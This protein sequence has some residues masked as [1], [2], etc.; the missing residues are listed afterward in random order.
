[1]FI[2][3][4]YQLNGKTLQIMALPVGFSLCLGQMKL[5]FNELM[6][7]AFLPLH[8]YSL[9]LFLFI[10]L[11]LVHY[12]F[13]LFSFPLLSYSPYSLA[14]WH[15]HRLPDMVSAGRH[16][17]CFF[18]AF[19]TSNSLPLRLLSI[20]RTCCPVPVAVVNSFILHLTWNVLPYR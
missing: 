8:D 18:C 6:E 13:F 16:S 10:A 11:I 2:Q 14:K 17:V 12:S 3:G 19:S 5:A 1:M 7:I 4:I 20:S 15:S 9:F